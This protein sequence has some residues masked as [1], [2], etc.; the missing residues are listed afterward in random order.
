MRILPSLPGIGVT[1]TIDTLIFDQGGVLVWAQWETAAGGW[2]KLRG[3]TPREVMER[4]IQG[5][6]YATFMRG[7]IDRAEFIKRTCARPR[8]N[9]QQDPATFDEMWCSIIEPNHEIVALIEELSTGYRMVIGS[10]TD[11]LYQER[12]E[13]VQPIVKPSIISYSPIN[14]VSSSLTLSFSRRVW[15]GS[16]SPLTSAS[17]LT[18]GTTT[19]TPL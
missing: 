14:W 12:I 13:E 17:S 5:E 6:A 4:L 8:L 18:I 10:N 15:R 11:E 2:S 3:T 19:W 1:L 16:I 9:I 7:E